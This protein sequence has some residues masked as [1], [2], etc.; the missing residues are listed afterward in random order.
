MSRIAQAGVER[1]VGF[2]DARCVTAA[3]IGRRQGGHYGLVDPGGIARS[4]I[5][6]DGDGRRDGVVADGA[7]VLLAAGP[8]LVI[9]A[10]DMGCVAA[11][12][13]AAGTGGVSDQGHAAVG[14]VGVFGAAPVRIASAA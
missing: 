9:P 8:S 1:V 4:W 5:G 7:I 11:L 14:E 12:R 6:R 3:G 2:V 13:Y 10:A